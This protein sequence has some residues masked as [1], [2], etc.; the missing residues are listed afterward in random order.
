MHCFQQKKEIGQ[1][2]KGKSVI[3]RLPA[4]D[5]RGT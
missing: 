2:V 1:V 4:F 5:S 3:P